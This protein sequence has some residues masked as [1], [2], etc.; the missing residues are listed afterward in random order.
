MNNNV[1]VKILADSTTTY[2]KCSHKTRITTF[3]LRYPRIIH[4]EFMTHRVFSRNSG[5][6][7]ARPIVTVLEDDIFIPVEFKSNK[8]G[9]QPGKALSQEKQESAR[10]IWEKAYADAAHY[11]SRLRDL[12]V[13]KQWA[14]RL[15]EPFSYINVVVTATTFENYF[16][17]RMDHQ[18]QDEIRYLA[19]AMKEKMD[20][21]DPIH[22][23]KGDWHLPYILDTDKVNDIDVI[24]RLSVARCARV[25]YK[26]FDMNE[27]S[28]IEDVWKKDLDLSH[29]LESSG[30]WSPFEHVV[31]PLARHWDHCGNFRGWK[32]FR[33]ELQDQDI[34]IPYNKNH[35][36]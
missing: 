13:H 34:L 1:D 21:S 8:K 35:S 7:R 16:N 17:L 30:H 36:I 32:S 12:G 25:S 18:S 23:C 26:P 33:S 5:S 4:S 15:T 6:S 20:S 27:T 24:K 22:I 9:M 29:K 3:Q 14:N 19:E 11:S 31:T 2:D 10:D 28:S